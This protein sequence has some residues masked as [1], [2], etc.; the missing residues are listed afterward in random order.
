M[1]Q[2]DRVTEDSGNESA[3]DA[4]KSKIKK[5]RQ[6]GLETAGEYSVENLTFKVLRNTGHIGKLYMAARRMFDDRLS[7]KE[8]HESRLRTLVCWYVNSGVNTGN[9]L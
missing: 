1:R 8:A 7:L 2:I 6:C 4:L 9:G 3:I 5:M